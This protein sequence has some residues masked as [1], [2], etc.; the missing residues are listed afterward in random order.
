M[1]S[2]TDLVVVLPGILG[3]TLRHRGKLVWSPSARSAVQAVKT[4]G[5]SIRDLLL[6]D[7]IGDDHPGDGV[8]PDGLMPDLH[9]LPGIWTPVKGYDRLIGRLRSLGYRE[10]TD[11]ATPGNLILFPYDWRLSNRYNARRLATVIEPALH[12]WREQGG[13][14]ADAQAVLVC[15]SMGGLIA[16]WYVEH[17]GGAETTRKV[18]T[19]GTPYRGAAKALEQLVNGVRRGVG[20]IGLDLTALVRSMPSMYQLLPEYACL[21]HDGGLAKTTEITVP[22]LS[23]SKIADGMRFHTE[24][25]QAESHRQA[26]LTTTHAIIGIQ[27]PT[28][29]TARLSGRRVEMVETYQTENLYGDATVPI[30]AAT[31]A[32]VPMDSPL[33][34][35]VPDQH[36]NLQRNPAA[37]DELEGILTARPID[38]RAPYSVDLR[39]DIPDLALAGEQLLVDVATA[40]GRPHSVRITV[41]DENNRI[42]DSRVT[43]VPAGARVTAVLDDQPPGAYAIAVS[44]ISPSSPLAPVNGDVLIW[45]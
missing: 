22:E 44:G 27:Q 16:R 17:C 19:F 45:G 15:H 9:A 1:T 28:S 41:T 39:V 3:S 12:R 37:L 38:V 32:D 24:L 14:F 42:V 34:R 36:G 18:V 35:R 20:P 13:R 10:P 25:A 30:V 23:T 40:D 33:L 21:E 29:T 11:D 4:F 6:P 2:P 7:D 31:R 5:G 8:E 26:S 43:Q